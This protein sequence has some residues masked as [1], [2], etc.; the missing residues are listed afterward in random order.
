[1]KISTSHRVSP[2]EIA[3]MYSTGIETYGSGI[4]IQHR[5]HAGMVVDGN[6]QR[7]FVL[8]VNA[9]HVQVMPCRVL[10]RVERP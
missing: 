1:M 6:S 4:R 2:R 5:L 10:N 9:L 3:S 8:K 7:D